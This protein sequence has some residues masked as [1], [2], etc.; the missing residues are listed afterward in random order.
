MR[1]ELRAGFLDAFPDLL[2]AGDLKAA[3]MTFCGLAFVGGALH[4]D[5]F[6]RMEDQGEVILRGSLTT[7]LLLDHGVGCEFP[8][9]GVGR[10][11]DLNEASAE[12]LAEALGVSL[13]EDD[14][15]FDL[16]HRALEEA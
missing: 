6:V 10:R 9:D 4:A 8:Q 11:V 7:P 16:V 15:E 5:K 13:G 3:A 1:G 14:E 2:I 12:S